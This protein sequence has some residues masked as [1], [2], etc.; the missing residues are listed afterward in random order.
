MKTSYKSA[1]KEYAVK[2]KNADG[3]DFAITQFTNTRVL[4]VAAKGSKPSYQFIIATPS[5]GKST[6]C[7]ISVGE[8][9]ALQYDILNNAPKKEGTNEID[10]DKIT[11][12]IELLE[13]GSCAPLDYEGEVFLNPDIYFSRVDGELLNCSK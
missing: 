8:L 11:N 9:K 2:R 3:L 1:K 4:T 13:D 12:A 10:Y 5:E 7:F 6:D